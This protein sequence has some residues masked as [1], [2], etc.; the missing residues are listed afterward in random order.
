[1]PWNYYRAITID[2]TLCGSSDSLFFPVLFDGTYSWLATLVNGGRLTDSNGYDVIFATDATGSTPIPYERVVHDVTTGAVEFHVQVPN[3]SASTDTVIYVLYGNSAITTDQSD[4]NGTWDSSFVAVWHFGD[5]TTLDLTDSTANGNNGTN[6]GGT[7]GAS[8][9]GGGVGGALQLVKASSQYVDVGTGA[10]LN[11]TGPYTIETQVY[12]D[13][14]ISGVGDTRIPY[15]RLDAGVTNGYLLA[16]HD[17]SGNIANSLYVQQFNGGGNQFSPSVDPNNYAPMTTR[18][19]WGGADG[20]N[21]NFYLEGTL[22]AAIGTAAFPGNNATTPTN[23]GRLPGLGIFFWDGRLDEMR[24]SNVARNLAWGTATSNSLFSP[25]T[26]YAVGSEVPIS[27]GAGFVGK[28]WPVGTGDPQANGASFRG[29]GWPIGTGARGGGFLG[30]GWPTASSVGV[31][32]ASFQGLGWPTGEAEPIAGQPQGC[33]VQP[34]SEPFGDEAPAQ[35][36]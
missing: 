33:V 7:A 6:H 26:F 1:M 32:P 36:F 25:S 9:C 35:I 24:I 15:G 18:R 22:H 12:A 28:G 14:A 17:N 34:A 19:P 21:L 20:T 29:L 11:L 30:S 13:S 23:I 2:H 4:R 10:S 3:L 8:L 5:G 31:V 16:L 27:P